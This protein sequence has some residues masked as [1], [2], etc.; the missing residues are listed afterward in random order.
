MLHNTLSSVEDTEK[1]TKSPPSIHAGTVRTKNF[2]PSKKVHER[3]DCLL[4][5]KSGAFPMYTDHEPGR[6]KVFQLKSSSESRF[7]FY[8]ESCK[9][10]SVSQNFDCC[11]WS[12][13]IPI[14][15]EQPQL[16]SP[17]KCS[18]VTFSS[19]ETQVRPLP[20]TPSG[21]RKSQDSLRLHQDYHQRFFK[22]NTLQVLR[23]V[24]PCFFKVEERKFEI[25]QDPKGTPYFCS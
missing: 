10:Q 23:E 13:I 15:W 19:L 8:C 20:S 4:E 17:T 14:V 2:S 25:W 11:L 21:L 5:K 22:K 24:D 6:Y 3:P 7:P 1:G 16:F 9:R 18:T 12:D